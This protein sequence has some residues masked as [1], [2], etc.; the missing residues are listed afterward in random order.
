METDVF[1]GRQAE[2]ADICGLLGRARH[3][4]LTGAAGAGKT[5]L[6]MRLAEPL[7]RESP[8]YVRIVDVS[9]TP[10]DL[11]A[12][13]ETVAG[14]IGAHQRPGRP[15]ERVVAELSANPGLVVLDG[16][17]RVAHTAGVL[18][19]HLLREVEG[20]HVLATSRQRLGFPHEHVYPIGGLSTADAVD[21][22]VMLAGDRLAGTDPAEICR[23]LDNLPLAIE[24]A[25][26]T[27]DPAGADLFAGPS[28]P[29]RDCPRPGGGPGPSGCASPRMFPRR[30]ASLCGALGMSYELCDPEERLVWARMSV[31]SECFD[32]EAAQSVCSVGDLSAGQVL[33]ALNGLTDRSVLTREGGPRG[34]RYRLLGVVRGFGAAR[35]AELGETCQGRRR[36]RDFFFGLA[37]RAAQGWKDDQLTWYRRLAPDLANLRQAVEYCYDR[38]EDRRQGLE[39]VSFLWF[40]WICCGNHTVGYSLLQR[41]LELEREPGTERNKALWVYAWMAI[42]RGDVED[43]ERALAECDT[44]VPGWD[45]TAYVSH[46]HAHLAMARGDL[47]EAMRFIKDARMRHRSAGDV[48]PGFLPTYVVVATALMLADRHEEAVSVL[49]EGRDL[50]ASC[51]DYWTLARLD[52]LLAQAEHL[53]G[54][55]PAAAAAARESMRGARLFGDDV[56][57]IEGIETFGVIAEGD[58]NDALAIRLLGAAAVA[59]GGAGL[60][61]CRAPIL[62]GLLE[63]SEERLRG[64][65]DEKEYDRLLEPGQTNGLGDAVEHALQGVAE[66]EPEDEYDD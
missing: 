46:F 24:L 51:G 17:D 49:H 53:L 28:D 43:A 13:T 27:P 1:V 64:R 65:T 42:Q 63:G 35:L 21:L 29:F 3:V 19:D 41:G 33:D 30:Y 18:V 20:L 45:S 37:A 14:A 25:A 47:T 22:L 40:L 15:V 12:L 57:L 61:P 7:E 32:A 60:P 59:R 44:G 54:N 52:L 5:R 8:G 56:C 55:T 31:F 4:T 36:H 2:L 10:D 6:A 26:E 58:G 16:C 9:E 50:C 38:P 11:L 39:L 48:F 23:R 34:A 66:S 62:A